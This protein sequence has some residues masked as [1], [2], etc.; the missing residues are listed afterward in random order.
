M[1]SEKTDHRHL[2]MHLIRRR[3]FPVKVTGLPRRGVAALALST[4]L[5]GGL[6]AP[7]SPASAL[8][9]RPF[10]SEPTSVVPEA[11]APVPTSESPEP[12][13]PSGPSTPEPTAD[14]NETTEPTE[15]PTT[16]EPGSETD[17][18][19]DQPEDQEPTDSQDPNPTS[20]P[21]DPLKSGKAFADL[22]SL[23]AGTQRWGGMNRYDTSVAVS[24][25][26]QPGVPVVFLAS[27][28]VFAD[29]LSGA[30]AAA[31]LG[32]PLL[33]TEPNRLTSVTRTELA[34]LK[35]KQIVVLGSSGA[36]SLSV[37][38]AAANI[39]PVKRWQGADR[40]ATSRA[41]VQQAFDSAP[42]VFLADGRSFPDGLTAAAAAG[43]L[44]APVI[45]VDGRRG[46]LP[47]ATMKQIKELGAKRAVLAG[48]APVLS[49]GIANQL[50][51]SGLTVA[52][53]GGSDRYETAAKINAAHF[54]AG[55]PISFIASGTA[56]PDALSA[57]AYAGAVRA[58]IFLVKRPYCM[59]TVEITVARKIASPTRVLLGNPPTVGSGA[60]SLSACP[61][62]ARGNTL[63]IGQI[64]APGTSIV[65]SNKKHR[66]TVSS[67]GNVTV[68]NHGRTRWTLNSNYPGAYLTLRSS[69][70]LTL[71]DDATARWSTGAQSGAA[72]VVIG[73]D[74]NLVI[75]SA[76]AKTQYW[77]LSTAKPWRSNNHGPAQ[78]AQTDPRWRNIRIGLSTLGPTGCVPTA[79]A[80][81]L[82]AYGVSATPVTVGKVMN[83]YGDFNRTAAGAG[84]ISIKK[85]AAQYGVMATPLTS[86]SAV[87][88]A[89]SQN[90]PVIALVRGPS[91]ITSPGSTH[92]VVLQG[93][94]NG[95]TTLYNPYG[96]IPPR[97]WGIDTLWSW[98]SYDSMD[99]NAG[100]VFWAIG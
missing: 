98:Q 25:Q 67:S 96:G 59:P 4:V 16:P 29:S 69:G 57:A 73:N 84:S 30:A 2:R 49:A 99:R 75:T 27:G 20:G 78:L 87:K 91:S 53:Y 23:P 5:V 42:A 47:A 50:S 90:R 89:L 77:S 100:A 80:M 1:I 8:T 62:Q 32:G 71:V 15:P 63:T 12:E 66:L 19:Q 22:P 31:Q 65:S 97:S 13:G 85:A 28:T 46:S 55:T 52:R 74:G 88:S 54:P 58:P 44:N 60:G 37:S 76:N 94:R 33:I 83:Q 56:F 61:Q 14:P 95:Q 51:K 24:R 45:L 48:G 82:R 39:A 35:P 36:V 43:T 18:D 81:T 41:I 92:A 3:K 68:L 79:M 64:L 72:R 93:N 70:A 9:A 21:T 38:K 86:Q 34:R 6:L 40:Y 17:Q 7:V 11:P 10:T 26:F